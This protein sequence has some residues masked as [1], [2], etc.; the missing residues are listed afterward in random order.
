MVF[1]ANGRVEA[2]SSS[3]EER[4]AQFLRTQSIRVFIVLT[5]V[6][7]LDLSARCAS[8]LQTFPYPREGGSALHL[9]RRHRPDALGFNAASLAPSGTCEGQSPRQPGNASQPRPTANPPIAIAA[10]MIWRLLWLRRKQPLLHALLAQR[11]SEPLL[12]WLV[13]VR[14]CLAPVAAIL[15]ECRGRSPIHA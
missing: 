6:F 9:R 11:Q 3:I 1:P 8:S 2:N 13:V 12:L 14:D 5:L 15:D 4:S 7:S 10:A